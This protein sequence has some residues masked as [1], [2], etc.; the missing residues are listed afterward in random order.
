MKTCN[1]AKP[2]PPYARVA[3]SSLSIML[4]EITTSAENVTLLTGPSRQP[5]LFSPGKRSSGHD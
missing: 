2:L 4:G 3:V 1:E 5:V